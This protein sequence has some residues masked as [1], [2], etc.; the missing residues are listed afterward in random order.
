MRVV[1]KENKVECPWTLGPQRRQIPLF[2]GWLFR[3]V[4]A[5]CYLGAPSRYINY[6]VSPHLGDTYVMAKRYNVVC[7]A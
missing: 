4:L 7:A 3:P 6:N 5:R 2:Y 1:K